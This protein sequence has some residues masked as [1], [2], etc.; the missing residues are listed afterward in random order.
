M[1]IPCLMYMKYSRV[2]KL[3][4]PISKRLMILTLTGNILSRTMKLIISF[5]EEKV[6]PKADLGYIRALL[7]V[8][9]N[10]KG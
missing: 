8:M 3:S 5:A 9:I 1:N 7:I 6:V 4:L 10:R 2:C